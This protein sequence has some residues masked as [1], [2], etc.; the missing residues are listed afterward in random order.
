MQPFPEIIN[1]SESKEY[2][3]VRLSKTNLADVAKLH[4]AVYGV[5]VEVDYFPKKYNT[6]YI[7]VEYVGFLAYD[8]SAQPVAY[9]GVIPCFLQYDGDIILSGQAAD[10]MTHPRHLGKG[11]F[12]KLSD[13]TFDLCKQLQLKLI[14]GF[15]NQRSYPLMI[16]YL[17]WTE[18]EKMY[19]FTI[20]V[21]S[22]MSMMPAF[23]KKINYNRILNQQ[24]GF[25]KGLPN[26]AVRDGYAGVYRDAAYCRYKAYN[27]THL[28]KIPAAEIWLKPGNELVIGDVVSLEPGSDDLF[29]TGLAQ[30]A[31]RLWMDKISF[32]VCSGTHLH[33][34]FAKRYEA[35]PSFPVL[36]KCFAPG[37]VPEKF[38][39]SFAD[40]DIF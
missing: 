11:L 17:G 26:S 40:I 5:S 16:K 7:G 14:F 19:R 30:L 10:G 33:Q 32:Q 28:I 2:S 12:V 36:V 35:V 24:P 37:I 34:L 15:P 8:Q 39:F 29:F 22:M 3:I 23:L 38:K 13:K 25:Q 18:I 21:N 6:T 27:K 4:A 1:K 31:G 20:P 9:F